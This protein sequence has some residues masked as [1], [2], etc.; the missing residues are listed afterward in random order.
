MTDDQD[1]VRAEVAALRAS[2]RADAVIIRAWLTM[3]RCINGTL[4][5]TGRR[6]GS[7]SLAD[8]H[9]RHPPRRTVSRR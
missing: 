5:N 4:A 8:H 7:S 1:Q 9:D 3:L 2:L 6:L